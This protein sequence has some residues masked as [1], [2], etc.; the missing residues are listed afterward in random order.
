MEVEQ[1]VW[2]NL[3]DFLHGKDKENNL[4]D[5]IDAQELND[6]LKTL[7]S[8]LT[9]KVFRTYNASYTLQRQLDEMSVGLLSMTVQ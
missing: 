6:Y 4:F 5:K 7:M 3:K 1:I 8:E 9:A 2:N